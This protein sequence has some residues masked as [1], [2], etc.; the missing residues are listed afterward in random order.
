MKPSLTVWPPGARSTAL[1]RMC[2]FRL[3]SAVPTRL[4]WCGVAPRGGGWFGEGN[5]EGVGRCMVVHPTLPA[6]GLPVAVI[7]PTEPGACL[8]RSFAAGRWLRMSRGTDPGHF[9]LS[10]RIN[11]KGC[12]VEAVRDRKMMVVCPSFPADG[13]IRQGRSMDGIAERRSGCSWDTGDWCSGLPTQTYPTLQ[14]R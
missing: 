13:L 10:T 5:L 11:P 8:F 9:N 7:S 12:V 6:N 2:L 3:F 1:A 14:D 4:A